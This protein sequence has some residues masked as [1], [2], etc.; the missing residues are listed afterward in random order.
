MTTTRTHYKLAFMLLIFSTQAQANDLTVTSF[1][2]YEQANNEITIDGVSTKYALG[3]TGIELRKEFNN[4]ITLSARAGYGQNANQSTSFGGANFNG[5]VT[6]SYFSVYGSYTFIE[7]ERLSLFGTTE[8]AHKALNAPDLVG[9][10]NGLDLTG[11]AKTTIKNA[12]L[13]FGVNY[14]LT[15]TL[16]AQLSAGVSQW[17][18]KSDATAY[19]SSNGLSATARKNIDARGTDPIFAIGVKTTK[20]NHNF[21]VKLLDRSLRS[22][23]RT[24]I[25]SAELTYSYQF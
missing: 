16:S 25:T 4:S 22:Q 17:Q 9:T 14:S 15:D 24:S 18:I 21:E 20:E 3:V 19:Y 8:F 11:N 23:T 2:L 1:G 12:D 5:K 13:L 6:G 7:R 10:R